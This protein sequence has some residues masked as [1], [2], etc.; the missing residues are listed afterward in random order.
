[1][2]TRVTSSEDMGQQILGQ[3]FA[4]PKSLAVTG[5]VLGIMGVI[6]GMPNLVFLSL[7]AGAGGGAYYLSRRKTPV[8]EL[9]EEQAAPPPA[10]PKELSWDDV[11][12]VDTIG[13]E[14]GYRLVPWWIKIRAAS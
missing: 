7:A 4:N 10:E 12:P 9:V 3:L 14:V 8:V 6:P 13:L 1:M 11:A 2:V 5:G